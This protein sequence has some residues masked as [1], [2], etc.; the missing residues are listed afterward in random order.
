MASH[1]ESRSRMSEI[2]LATLNARYIHSALGLRYL[3]ANMGDLSPRTAVREFVINDHPAEILGKLLEGDPKIIGLGIYIWNLEPTT[4]VLADLKRVCPEVC[5]VLGGPE[6]SYDQA[7]LPIVALADY[8]ITGEADLAFP[9]FCRQYLR[10]ERPGQKII[11]A[12]LPDTK[13]LAMPYAYYTPEDIAHR[14][15]YVEAS[16]G[17]PFTCEFCLSSLDIPVRQ[18]PVEQFL[19]EVERLMQAGVRQFKF[20]D[21]TFNLNLK[22]S[23]RILEFFLERYTPDLFLHFEMIPDRL[24][25]SLRVLLAQF[26]PG[27]IQLEVGIQSFDEEV[28]RWISRQ[29]DFEQIEKNFEYLRQHTGAHL[30]AD[31]IVGLPGET[32]ESFAAGFDRLYRLHP[33]EIQVGILKRLRG[34]PLVRHDAAWKM[35][36]SAYPPYE[37]LSHRAMDFETIQQL[38]RFARYWDL[39]GNSGNFVETLAWLCPPST[40]AF[41]ALDELSRWLYRQQP[42]LYGLS[43][44]RLVELVFIYLTEVRGCDQEAVAVALAHDYTRSVRRELPGFLK[45]AGAGKL[46]PAA[47]VE[48]SR[49]PQR[50]RRHLAGPDRSLAGG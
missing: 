20:V 21:R 43:L 26:P 40:S 19:A 37:I 12:A 24:P 41:Q 28:G 7:E 33:Q 17:C 34:T 35:V 45:Q 9:A 50:Q 8:V 39:I 3:L 13:Q 48:A 5:V 1:R 49:L 10:G 14:I 30:H 31:L 38:R 44:V 22:V 11:T 2:I 4:R 23:R 32:R 27:A 47:S 25:E 29:Q 36:Y 46:S 15:I 18:F 42:Q 6:V 16:R